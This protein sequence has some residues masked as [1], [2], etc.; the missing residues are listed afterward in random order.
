M[1]DYDNVPKRE[2][3]CSA[4]KQLKMDIVFEL[5][6]HGSIDSFR[7]I[8]RIIYGERKI[9]YRICNLCYYRDALFNAGTFGGFVYYIARC[10]KDNCKRILS[11]N[12][13]Y[14]K[15]MDSCLDNRALL[16]CSICICVMLRKTKW[17]VV[18]HDAVGIRDY[19]SVCW[20][21]R[22][23]RLERIFTAGNGKDVP[24]PDCDIYYRSYL[25]CMAPTDMGYAIF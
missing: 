3:I 4:E 22:R 9:N 10:R 11:K 5:I 16:C 8:F 6:C 7:A 17:C 15:A 18:V 2:R 14:W 25:V 20:C 23:T 12:H 1:Y 19:D 21:R 24:V 13:T